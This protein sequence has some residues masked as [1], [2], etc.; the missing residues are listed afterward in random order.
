MYILHSLTPYIKPKCV[1]YIQANM[2]IATYI[3]SMLIHARRTTP[4]SEVPVVVKGLK[5]TTADKGVSLY[6]LLL[7]AKETMKV[8]LTHM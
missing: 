5:Y 4:T 3:V 2:T 1:S 6:H 8:Y 7:P